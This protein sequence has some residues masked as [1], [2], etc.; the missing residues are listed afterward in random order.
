MEF[1]VEKKN[2]IRE[3]NLLAAV[4]E[5]KEG[6]PML[7]NIL[8]SANGD[9]IHLSGTDLEVSLSTRCDGD[10]VKGGVRAINAKRFIDIVK[11][12]EGEIILTLDNDGEWVNIRCGRAKFRIGSTSQEHFPAIPQMG[13]G[14]FSVPGATLARMVALTQFAATDKPGKYGIA[15]SYLVGEGQ[16]LKMVATDGHRLSYVES[17]QEESVDGLSVIIPKRA[18][19][20]LRSLASEC[21]RLEIEVADNHVFFKADDR[22][23]ASRV[24]SAKFVDYRLVIPQNSPINIEVDSAPL[25][26]AVTRVDLLADSTTRAVSFELDDGILLLRTSSQE[27]GDAIDSFEIDYNGKAPKV[28]MN[29]QYLAEFLSEVESAKISIQ[30]KDEAHPVMF[31]P[32]TQAGIKHLYVVMPMRISF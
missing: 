16:L 9:G 30:M 15:G 4:T 22:T 12:V 24:I 29:A 6:I 14:I 18:L 31:T 3:L 7:G 11:N 20:A 28:G 19:S 25:R 5:K 2:L 1:T 8:V 10:T 32:V 21:S 27:K 26:G 13:Q 23:F 17:A